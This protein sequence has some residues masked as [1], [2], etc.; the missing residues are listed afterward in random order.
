MTV[1]FSP[2]LGPNRGAP[3][4]PCPGTRG[5]SGCFIIHSQAGKHAPHH[6][7]Q[8][9]TR[10]QG[11]GRRFQTQRPP[12]TA[13]RPAGKPHRAWATVISRCEERWGL[14][15]GI[16]FFYCLIFLSQGYMIRKQPIYILFVKNERNFFKK[17]SP[18]G[19]VINE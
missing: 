18:L 3:L 16:F 5:G 19:L 7:V 12:P 8:A 13:H 4:L 15:I 10:C 6:T 9:H 1:R 2:P 14:L 17:R 11:R